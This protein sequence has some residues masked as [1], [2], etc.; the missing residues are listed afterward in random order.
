MPWSG[1]TTKLAAE[2]VKCPSL[3]P[4][5]C[6]CQDL[7]REK[8]EHSGFDCQS[9]RDSGTVN[10]LARHGS[11]SPFLL[12]LGH[13]DVVPA[14]DLHAW[15]FPPFEGRIAEEAGEAWLCGRGSADMKGA[16]AAMACALS[17]FART[18]P[19]HAGTAGV[20]L[21]SNEEGDSRGGT[22]FAA[23]WLK[24]HSL[25]PDYC[26]VGEPSCKK[27]FGDQ[28][29]NGRRGSLQGRVIVKG[30]QGHVAYPGN[31]DNAA[32]RA[33]ALICRLC[34]VRWDEGSRF[35][36]PTSFQVTNITCGTGAENVVPGSCGFWCNWR[37]N[38][39]VSKESIEQKVQ[40][41][42]KEL[43]TRAEINWI[44][45]GLPFLTPGGALLDALRAAVEQ[46]S[47][48]SPALSTSGGTSDG[49]F[50]APLGAQTLEFGPVSEGIH[51]ANERVSVR[52]LEQLEQIYFLVLERLLA[53]GQQAGSRSAA[54]SGS[55]AGSGSSGPQA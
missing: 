27:F 11:G 47:G 17:R 40:E 41:V 37:Y 12:F 3:T 30:V 13:T 21:T 23:E 2:L 50:I 36:P 16:D 38:D 18:Y 22:P 4:D 5:D 45:S 8:L 42:L 26:L 6:G 53:P 55:A 19:E 46:I 25:I 24:R 35:F 43:G 29:K 1:D 28:I 20:L 9:L 14:G 7:I 48:L 33:A 49:R 52:S 51:K 10:L 39:L 15:N 44:V 32:H 34:A 54:V 31:C